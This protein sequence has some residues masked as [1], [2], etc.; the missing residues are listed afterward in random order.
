MIEDQDTVALVP[1]IILLEQD[2]Q[3]LKFKI[4]YLILDFDALF[5]FLRSFKT[6]Y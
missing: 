5:E 1:D 4:S 6:D 3:T 2:L